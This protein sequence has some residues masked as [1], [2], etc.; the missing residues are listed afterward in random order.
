LSFFF[1]VSGDFTSFFPGDAFLVDAGT[2]EKIE[3]TLTV[4]DS[5][6]SISFLFLK[7]NYLKFLKPKL[8]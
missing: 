6:S 1:F 3:A 5:I 8:T 7:R 2:F 4:F